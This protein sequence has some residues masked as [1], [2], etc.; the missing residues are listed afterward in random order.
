M[1]QWVLDGPD[2]ASWDRFVTAA[3][4][5]VSALTAR[6]H[7]LLRRELR[8]LRPAGLRI[9]GRQTDFLILDDTLHPRTGRSLEGAGYHFSHAAGG[10]T[11]GHSLVTCAYRT[12]DYTFAYSC[13]PYVRETELDALNAQTT[14][15]NLLRPPGERRSVRPFQSKIDLVVAQLQAFRP[16]QNGRPVFT[17]FDSWYLN[18]RV[19]R[20]ARDQGLDWCSCLKANRKLTLL[21]L[22]LDTGEVQTVAEVTVGDLLGDLVPAAVLTAAGVPYP[23]ACV[24]AS[25][26]PFTVAGRTFRAVAYRA[27]L[28]GIGL[29][30]VVL[31]QEQYR[32]G[33][34]S[35]VVPLVTNRLDLR[36]AEVVAVYLQRWALEV[37]HRDTKQQLGLTDCQMQSLEGS[38]RHWAMVFLSQTLLMLLRLQAEHGEVRTVSGQPVAQVGRT[39][40]EVRQFVKQCAL[41]ELLGWACQQA[42]QGRS[43]TEIATALGLPA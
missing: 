4:W 41:V 14:H 39:V 6:A 21:D 29:V 27:R 24:Q 35:P 1:S 13:A 40:G 7:Q 37:L 17:L 23:A 43:V 42:V 19:A 10:A 38:T 11:L 28:T 9:A 32:S 36:P 26:E 18:P 34:W 8:R 16:L 2:P 22:S 3:P 12:G 31:A 30:Q 25:W 20:A 15:D 5:E 33:R